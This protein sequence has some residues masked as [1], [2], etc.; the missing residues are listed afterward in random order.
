[1]QAVPGEGEGAAVTFVFSCFF[2]PL[3]DFGGKRASLLS[4]VALLL[5][6]TSAL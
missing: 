2:A 3:R 6:V 1:M 5:R 4:R